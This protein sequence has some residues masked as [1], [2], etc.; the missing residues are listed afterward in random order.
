VAEDRGLSGVVAE[1]GKN[2]TLR[3]GQRSQRP[4]LPLR[5]FAA[6]SPAVVT[7][8]VDVLPAPWREMGQQVVVLLFFVFVKLFPLQSLLIGSPFGLRAVHVFESSSN[9]KKAVQ[10]TFI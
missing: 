1:N 8:R 6:L 4:E 10:V 3:V 5:K 9:I 7:S 2:R